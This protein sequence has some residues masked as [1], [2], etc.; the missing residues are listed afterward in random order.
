M[1][2]KAGETYYL[3]ISWKAE[4]TVR[5]QGFDI[6]SLESARYDLKQLKPIDDDNLKDKSRI[7]TKLGDF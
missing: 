2:F 4:G 7:T 5:A 3:R 6:V 1:D